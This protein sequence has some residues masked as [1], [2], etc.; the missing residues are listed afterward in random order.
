MTTGQDLDATADAKHATGDGGV[1]RGHGE[2]A[3]TGAAATPAPPPVPRWYTAGPGGAP[4]G[5][6]TMD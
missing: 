5:P 2:P 3:A 4:L 1:H 6:W